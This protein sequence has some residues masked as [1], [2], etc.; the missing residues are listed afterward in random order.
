MF[1]LFLLLFFSGASAHNDSETAM[2]KNKFLKE[3]GCRV[4]D[5]FDSLGDELKAVYDEFVESG[6]IKVCLTC[7][8]KSNLVIFPSLISDKL[9]RLLF[10]I[11]F[12]ITLASL[13]GL[14]Y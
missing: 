5:S 11:V 7:L 10:F 8:R 4:P 6:Q 12:I 2:A 13:L 1:K 9:G 14:V 3:T